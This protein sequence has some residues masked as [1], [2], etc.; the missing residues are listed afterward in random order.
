MFNQNLYFKQNCYDTSISCTSSLFSFFPN[1]PDGW[2][3]KR[4]G[5]PP[6][7]WLPWL[8]FWEWQGSSNGMNKPKD[9]AQATSVPHSPVD[10]VPAS[11]L[12]ALALSVEAH[13]DDLRRDHH[14]GTNWAA[15]SWHQTAA[16]RSESGD[17]GRRTRLCLAP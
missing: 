15:S 1:I 9:S 5:F 7:R 17:L 16:F 11:Q 3:M 10:R 4:E 6:Q 13:A 8:P 2:N 12:V 14:S